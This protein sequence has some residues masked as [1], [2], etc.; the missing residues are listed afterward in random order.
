MTHP[1]AA[2]EESPEIDRRGLSESQLKE[3][4]VSINRLMTDFPKNPYCKS[5]C[6]N[7]PRR[8]PRK[9]RTVPREL[10]GKFGSRL[11]L[12]HVHAHSEEM[13]GIDGSMDV[14]AFYD[15]FES[16]SFVIT[17]SL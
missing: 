1:P 5:C 7:R 16:H 12:D 10:I 2:E 15:L 11:T 8:K 4:A 17:C 14:L 3:K 13:E 9:R 6:K